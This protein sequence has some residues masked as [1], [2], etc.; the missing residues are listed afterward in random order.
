MSADENHTYCGCPH[1]FPCGAVGE[2]NCKLCGR[3]L[4]REVGDGTHYNCRRSLSIHVT[5]LLRNLV[6]IGVAE[7]AFRL[8]NANGW[9]QAAISEGY[10]SSDSWVPG[11]GRSAT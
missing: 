5:I 6:D 9:D 1:G 2:D 11:C 10:K 4:G 3:W 8:G 7:R